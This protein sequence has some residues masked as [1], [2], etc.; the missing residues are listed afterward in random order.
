MNFLNSLQLTSP[1]AMVLLAFA[2]G[3][4]VSFVSW[5]MLRC[6]RNMRFALLLLPGV[7]CAALLAIN[8]N[9]GTGIA[10]LG[11]FGLV[12]FRSMPGSATD[13]VAVFYAMVCGLVASTGYVLAALAICLL[14]GLFI[15]AAGLVL[16]TGMEVY[17]LRILVPED[18][19]ST[20]EYDAVLKKYCSQVHFERLKTASMGS[21]YELSYQIV[22]KANVNLVAVLDAI[23]V[24]NHN[25]SVSC[26]L[27]GQEGASL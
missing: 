23:R 14:I 8:G 16:K 5:K 19:E 4:I 21:M 27:S 25:L 18:V 6:T 9:L 22:P 3:C 24:L 20:A 12:R 26:F 10:I 13:I 11:V 2:M 7:V 1:V 17:T 15:L